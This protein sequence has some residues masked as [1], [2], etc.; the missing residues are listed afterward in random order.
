MCVYVCV[1]KCG[2]VCA[3]LCVFVFALNNEYGFSMGAR[4]DEQVLLMIYPLL[5]GTIT[6]NME[7]HDHYF[8][9][10]H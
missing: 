5:F 6:V 10:S 7:H 4:G 1:C 2:C 9:P 3:H 8:N